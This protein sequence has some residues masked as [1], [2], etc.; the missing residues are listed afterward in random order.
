MPNVTYQLFGQILPY[1]WEKMGFSHALIPSSILFF[2][3]LD[4]HT[5]TS[6][7]IM[8]TSSHLHSSH[9]HVL[10]D[11]W[12]LI[13]APTSPSIYLRQGVT[14]HS[15]FISLSRCSVIY[16]H[17]KKAYQSSFTVTAA[18]SA[19]LLSRTQSRKSRS[20]RLGCISLEGL[21]RGWLDA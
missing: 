19:A 20:I 6:C 14:A 2:T 11:L 15:G 10:A 1:S 13:N 12:A 7:H 17:L 4:T 9:P 18:D 16:S 8:M 21:G 5:H 3:K